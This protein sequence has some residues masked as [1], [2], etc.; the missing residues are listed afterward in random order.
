MET[1]ATEALYDGMTE[2]SAE[3]PISLYL[4]IRQR[5]PVL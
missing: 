1:R 3:F 2:S 4:D 5:P